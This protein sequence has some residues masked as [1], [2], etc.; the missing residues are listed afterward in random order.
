[1]S[2]RV[3]ARIRPLLKAEIEKDVIV[4]TAGESTVKIPNPKKE[5]EAFSFHFNS[6]YDREA[7]QAQIFDNEG[8]RDDER[9]GELVC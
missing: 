4:D 1:M 7:T 9:V 8:K 2:V 5:A 3:I 6:V